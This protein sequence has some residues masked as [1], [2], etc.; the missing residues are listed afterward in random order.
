[1]PSAGFEPATPATK[2]PQTY[3]LDRADTE[4][5]STSLHDAISQKA[6]IFNGNCVCTLQKHRHGAATQELNRCSALVLQQLLDTLSSA[7]CPCV[8]VN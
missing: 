6:I 1:M 8:Y 3:A 4:V 5:G 7:V 2:R